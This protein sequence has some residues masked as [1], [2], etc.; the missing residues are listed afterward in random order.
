[1]KEHSTLPILGP[2]LIF[3]LLSLFK[4]LLDNDSSR[5]RKNKQHV[6]KGDRQGPEVK[7]HQTFLDIDVEINGP[8]TDHEEDQN[9]S[10]D[11]HC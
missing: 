1:M 3:E 10:N 8:Y 5:C 4:F 6:E 7:I 9:E 11:L 2:V